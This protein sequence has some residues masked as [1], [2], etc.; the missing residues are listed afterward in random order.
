MVLDRN[1]VNGARDPRLQTLRRN[2]R[3]LSDTR[4]AGGKLAPVVL[5]PRAE[6]SDNSHT[7]DDDDRS[8]G[9][10]SLRHTASPSVDRFDESQT[11]AA[12]VPDARH[13]HLPQWRIHRSFRP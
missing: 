10:V 13:H 5:A 6:R 3:D 8:A 2:T 12:P 9:P 7:G 11:L 4:L 1:E